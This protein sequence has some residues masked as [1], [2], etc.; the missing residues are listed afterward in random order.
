MLEH[1]RRLL[2]F[3]SGRRGGL[4]PLLGDRWRKKHLS[5]VALLSGVEAGVVW[6]SSGEEEMGGVRSS[7]GEACGVYWS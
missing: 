3:N 7:G 2:P 5:G 1:L 6:M 4:A